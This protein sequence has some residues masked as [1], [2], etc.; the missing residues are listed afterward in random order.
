MKPSL[1]R[2]VGFSGGADSQA[3][4]LWVRQHFP[5]EEIILLN[6]DPGGN[7]NVYTYGFIRWY[8]ENVFPVIMV[9]PIVADVAERRPGMVRELGLAPD[10]PLTFDLLA[11]IFQRFPSDLAGFC[12]EFLK[13]APSRRWLRENVIAR[14]PAITLERYVGVRRDES[15]KRRNTPDKAWDDYFDC[16]VFYPL[17]SWTKQ[18]V[19]DFLKEHGEEVNPLYKMGFSRVGCSPCVKWGKETIRLWAA[20]FPDEVAKVRQWEKD[21]GYT[22]FGPIMTDGSFGFI[23]EVVEWSKTTR[24]GRQLSLPFVEN[25]AASGGC[26]SKYG[27]CE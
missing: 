1:M 23:D 16:E 8:S 17:A 6:A 12:T 25:D 20:R 24:G 4:A 22:F 21:V 10:Q 7:E 15:T 3:T 26:V 18:Q 5:R 11:K 9:Q 2:V 13:L 14:N 27:L 19:F